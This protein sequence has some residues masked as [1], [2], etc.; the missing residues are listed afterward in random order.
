MNISSDELALIPSDSVRA[1]QNQDGSVLLDIQQGLCFSMTHVGA[2]IWD[3]LKLKSSPE[4]ISGALAVEFSAPT[5]QVHEDVVAFISELKKQGLLLS[6]DSVKPNRHLP[7]GPALILRSH[8]MWQEWFS[9][10][11]IVVCLLPWKAFIALLVFD[12]WRFGSSFPRLHKFVAGWTL[13]LRG[14]PSETVEQVCRAVDW[15]CVFYPKRVLCLQR[16]AITTCLLRSSGVPAE[17]VMGAQQLPFKAHAWTEVGG[18]AVNERR[19]VQSTYVVWE[20]C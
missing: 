14:T 2:R 8:R 12:L 19:D 17:M 18:A 5:T 4:Q 1:I 6:S 11:P 13:T 3:L 10:W 9:G 15:A 20:R 16:S 7:I